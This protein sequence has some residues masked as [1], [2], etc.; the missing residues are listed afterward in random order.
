MMYKRK[1]SLKHFLNDLVNLTSASMTPERHYVPYAINMS[2]C[3]VFIYPPLLN[4]MNLLQGSQIKVAGVFRNLQEVIFPCLVA[5]TY[6]SICYLLLQILKSCKNT[7]RKKLDSPFSATVEM[8]KKNYLDVIRCIDTFED[9]FSNPIFMIVFNDFCI[10]SFVIMDMMYLPNWMLK[11]LLESL[12]YL[13]FILGILGFL[14][15]CAADVQL[16]M[17]SIKSVLLEKMISHPCQ[18]PFPYNEPQ[19]NLL[20]KKSVCTLT[21]GRAFPFDRGFLLK[22]LAAVIAQA[23]IIYQLGLSL[24]QSNNS[25]TNSCFH[26]TSNS[27]E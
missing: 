11:F 3:L 4:V 12:T 27:T 2:M 15:I 21:A 14:T 25:N 10:V 8:L 19:I 5:I 9:L 26:L 20:L 13:V 7:V 23:V 6:S 22:A 24:S 16:E 17:L 1:G 18:E